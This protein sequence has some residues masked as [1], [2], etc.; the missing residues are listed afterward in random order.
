MIP[1]VGEGDNLPFFGPEKAA[2]KRR[3]AHCE[4]E[5]SEV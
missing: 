5:T 1:N 4:V 3:R 2:Y